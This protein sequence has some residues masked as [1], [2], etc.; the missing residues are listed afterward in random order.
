MEIQQVSTQQLLRF[1]KSVAGW[2]ARGHNESWPR[3]D[4]NTQPSELESDALP[5][6]HGVSMVMR[7]NML[8][9]YG[10][11][12]SNS[13]QGR[14]RKTSDLHRLAS[15]LLKVNHYVQ[16]A[17][18]AFV[19]IISTFFILARRFSR[20][21]HKGLICRGQFSYKWRTLP[22][23]FLLWRSYE[24]FKINQAKHWNE[25]KTFFSNV[26]PHPVW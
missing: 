25:L 22:Y 17:T 12:G 1:C 26:R 13:F 24:F 20:W 10:V 5:L 15:F 8:V 19:W 3:R 14:I 2:S 21:P 11:R 18:I 4:S 7:C 6:R 9:V 16:C 23:S